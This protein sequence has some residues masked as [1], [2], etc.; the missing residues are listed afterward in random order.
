MK[1]RVLSL[2]LCFL[3][4]VFS[5]AFAQSSKKAV[6]KNKIKSVAVTRT[7]IKDGK[8]ITLKESFDKYDDHGNNIE[9]IEYDD[10]GEVKKHESNVYNKNNDKTENI[11][12]LSDGKMKKKKVIKYDAANKKTEEQY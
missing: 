5:A 11:D 12:Y 2:T 4:S 7:V 6:K 3:F 9:S 8:E 1:A 10:N